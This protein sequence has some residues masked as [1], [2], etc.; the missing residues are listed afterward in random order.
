[1]VKTLSAAG[2]YQEVLNMLTESGRP[3]EP[4]GIDDLSGEA[5]SAAKQPAE[6]LE[7]A[8]QRRRDEAP[9]PAVTAMM[10][11]LCDSLK[12][13]DCA[14]EHWQIAASLYPSYLA[15]QRRVHFFRAEVDRSA[16][17]QGTHPDERTVGG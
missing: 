12:L 10:A 7:L 5:A 4:V 16:I 11:R 2:R 3:V 13:A 17:S 9:S 8:K 14:A 6:L 15:W 1:M